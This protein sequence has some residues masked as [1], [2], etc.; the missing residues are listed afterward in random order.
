MLHGLDYAF[1]VL[2]MLP[3]AWEMGKTAW[4]VL[5]RMELATTTTAG[6]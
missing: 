4:P 3:V 1:F 6:N 5:Q 2:S